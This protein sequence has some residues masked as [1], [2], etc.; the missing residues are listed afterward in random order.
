MSENYKYAESHLEDALLEL[1]EELGWEY[2]PGGKT[3]RT[4]RREVILE[5]KLRDAIYRLNPMMPD[6]VKEDALKQVM[7]LPKTTLIKSNE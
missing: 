4:D 5:E 2:L 6:H 7:R 1:L 3:E